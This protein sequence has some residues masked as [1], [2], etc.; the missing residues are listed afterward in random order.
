MTGRYHGATLTREFEGSSK[1]EGCF[2]HKAMMH[3]S[4]T[5]GSLGGG[6]LK[7]DCVING[8][9]LVIKACTANTLI[10]GLLWCYRHP[11]GSYPMAPLR[12]R[13]G[14]TLK[15]GTQKAHKHKHLIRISLPYWASL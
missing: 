15:S 6:A 9:G 1:H 5:L 13:W 8:S 2:Q 12:Q 10:T 3:S 11:Q 4:W 7:I 14:M